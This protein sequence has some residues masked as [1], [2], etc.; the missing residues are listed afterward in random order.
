MILC[1]RSTVSEMHRKH[2][3]LQ[4]KGLVSA[5]HSASGGR[6]RGGAGSSGVCPR[7][8]SGS[9]LRTGLATP[10]TSELSCHQE[11]PKV[12]VRTLKWVV[13]K[14]EYAYFKHLKS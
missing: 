6:C 11:S 13:L 10:G 9:L 7:L 4:S 2:I 3:H 8:G 1:I 5:N 14:S 12:R